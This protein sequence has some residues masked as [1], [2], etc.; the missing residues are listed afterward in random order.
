MASDKHE[1]K[2]AFIFDILV[3]LLKIPCG[4]L[5]VYFVSLCMRI[6][7]HGIMSKH[8]SRPPAVFNATVLVRRSHK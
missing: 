2:K 1:Q 3:R 6:C 8:F 4:Q 5:V 7:C